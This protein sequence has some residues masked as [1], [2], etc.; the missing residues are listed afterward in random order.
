MKTAKSIVTLILFLIS[1]YLV[2]RR[3]HRVE[4]E[5]FNLSYDVLV[6]TSRACDALKL[7]VTNHLAESVS[8]IANLVPTG[9]AEPASQSDWLG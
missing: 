3:T 2:I 5:F 9:P 6:L 8:M 4:T 7:A 1:R